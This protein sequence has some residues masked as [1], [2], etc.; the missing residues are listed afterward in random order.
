MSAT[1]SR[2]GPVANQSGGHVR[3]D[4]TI[5]TAVVVTTKRRRILGCS[6][7]GAI[8]RPLFLCLTKGRDH[9]LGAATYRPA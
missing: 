2:S 1:P 9:G 8:S 7:G 3:E 6:S 4:G 5:V